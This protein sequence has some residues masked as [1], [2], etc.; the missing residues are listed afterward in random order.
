MDKVTVSAAPLR[1]LLEA[2]IGPGHLVRE[3]QAIASVA[4]DS[5][6]PIL[7]KE[8]NQAVEEWNKTHG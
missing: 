8:F 3:L 4:P 1:E 7:V 6:L 5:P 2:L